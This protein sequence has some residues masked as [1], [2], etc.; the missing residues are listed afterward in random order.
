MLWMKAL[1]LPILSGIVVSDW[2]KKS[3]NFVQE[4]SRKHYF[5]E[6]LLRVDRKGERWTRRRGG[7][8]L[9]VADV[10]N[11]VDQLKREGFITILLEPV[12]PFSDEYSFA[13]VTIPDQEKLIVEVVG[14]GFDASDIL[15]SDV[16]AHERWEFPLASFPHLAASTISESGKRIGLATAEQY[17]TSVQQRLAKIGARLRNP[18]FPDEAS[19]E[20]P[21]DQLI[22]I[23]RSFL[24]DSSQTRLLEASDKYIP[25]PERHLQAFRHGVERVLLGLWE[26]GVHLSS[27]SFAGSVIPNRGLVFWD[28][29]PA[30]R[31]EAESLFP[32]EE[33]P[34][35]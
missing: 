29:F 18:A 3:A 10:H 33:T 17:A 30:V 6:L 1:G 15:R 27:T 32:G 9:P 21:K 35:L 25:A 28:F 24:R 16:P 11:T 20:E 23:A 13:G 4:F 8:L 22:T 34:T 12:S 14:P 26:H 2:S 7:Y 31:Q 5:T 19:R